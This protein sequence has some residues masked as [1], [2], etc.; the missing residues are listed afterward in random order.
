MAESYSRWIVES[1]G[2][3]TRA[4]VKAYVE[5]ETDKTATIYI[6]GCAQGYRLTKY[7]VASSC[8]G[9][10]S[11]RANIFSAS[12]TTNVAWCSGRITVDK[13]SGGHYETCQCSIW[14]VTVNGYGPIAGSATASVSVWVSARV[15]RPPSA[16]TNLVAARNAQANID[17]SWANNASNAVSTLIERCQK[18]GAW[19]VIADEQAVL[20]TYTDSPLIGSF[21]YRVRYWNSDGYSGYSNETDY[22]VTLCAPAAPTLVTPL[23]GSVIDANAQTV[24]MSWLH[25]PIDTSAQ[26]EAELAWSADNVNYTFVSL[27]TQSSYE[28]AIEGNQILYW[29]V[30]TKGAHEDY[31]P[32]SAVSAFTVR[33]APVATLVLDSVIEELPIE[34]SWTYDDAEGEQAAYLVEI[35]DENGILRHSVRGGSQKSLL[36]AVTEFTPENGSVYTVA[37]TV[38]STTS[39]SYRTAA[40]VRVEYASPASPSLVL[41]VNPETLSVKATVFEGSSEDDVPATVSLS[42]FRG[43]DL[44]A[45]NL[46]NGQSVMDL[47]PPLDRPIA[48]RAVAY[49]MSGSA[50]T[51]KETIVAHSK[52]FAFFNYGLDFSSVAKLSLDYEESDA[53]EH[54]HELYS[55]ASSAYPKVFYGKHKTRS[56]TI[57]GTVLWESDVFE[58]GSSSMLSAFEE[59]KDYSGLT[60]M[61]LPYRDEMH[62]L[63]TVSLKRSAQRYGIA[64]VSIDWQVVG[65]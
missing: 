6:T 31:G 55:V 59:L 2:G 21:K 32:W 7:G 62:V 27:T 11:N 46:K 38:T 20:T 22:I 19:E 35:A 30:R 64:A 23:S 16:P 33:T 45:E 14:G 5:S 18:G 41:G 24:R 28:I 8:T 52:G 4:Y 50:A 12:S 53:S 48:Y 26:T 60:Y 1:H 63:C 54:E 43:D 51:R 58:A 25:N 65:A 17:L 36:I 10:G 42:L 61:R 3:K 40:V 13:T 29:K 57:S 49:G 44:I 15:L 37:L 47:V 34:L 56:G 9:G 39:L